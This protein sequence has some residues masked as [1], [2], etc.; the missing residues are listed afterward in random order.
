MKKLLNKRNIITLGIIIVAIVLVSS[1]MVLFEGNSNSRRFRREYQ[2]INNKDNGKGKKYR[3][4]NI[5]RN[6]PFIYATTEDIV[7]KV[8]NKE[9]FIVYFGFSECPW[10]RSIIEELIHA[11][12]DK[13]VKTI[14]Y[15][16]IKDIRNEKKVESNGRVIT[17]KKGDDNY[18][19]LLEKFHDILSDYI[20]YMDDEKV[21]DAS[22]RIYAPTVIAVSKGEAIQMET[23]IPE[24]LEDP[25]SKLTKSMKKYT[26]NKFKCLIKCLEDASN[27]CKKDM[28]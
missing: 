26:Y 25:Y 14:Y 12:K 18:L 9:S 6:N 16:N 3:N 23:G 22:K 27:T 15:V 24:D 21:Y 17:T 8:N 5:P 11:A 13:K 1:I 7:E 28:C 10:C 4:L 20:L 19:V 2:S